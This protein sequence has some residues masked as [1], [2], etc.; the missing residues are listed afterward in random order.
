LRLGYK[1]LIPFFLLLSLAVVSQNLTFSPY[2]RYGIGEMNH[3]GFGQL[4]ALGGA[5]SAFKPDT[6]APVFINIV[7]PAAIS[8]IRVTTLEI[9]GI[10]NFS[11]Y[12]NG[13]SK[14]RTKTANFSY[15]ALG[16]NV[17]Q[18]A[19]LCFGIMP[20]SNVGYNIRSDVW[21]DN[22]ND[23]VTTKYSGD[24][25]INKVFLGIG[26]NPFKKQLTKFYRSG[27]RDSLMHHHQVKKYKRIKF[28]KE[29]L[30]DLSIGGRADYLFGNILQTSS[31]IYPGS[32][33]YYNTRRYRAVNYNDIT[34]SLGLQTSFVIDSVKKKKVNS[35]THFTLFGGD[36]VQRYE[37]KQ[38]IRIAFG[39]YVNIPNT[40]MVKNS[41]LAYN[42]SL[43]S[44]GDEIPKDTFVYAMD[45]QGSI[46]LPLEQGIG[47]SVKKGEVLN[48]TA[49]LTYTNW[50]Q[51][52]YLDKVNDLRNSYR[53]SFGINYVPNKF[54]LGKQNYYK[55]VNYR[56]GAFYNNGYLELKKSEI[57][58]YALTVGFGFPVGVI[59]RSTNNTFLVNTV[60]ISAHFGKMGT[61][62]NKL[63]EEKYIKLV[64]GFTFND[65]WFNKT[66]FD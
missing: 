10:G 11:D 21:S 65:K 46:R 55:R 28:A 30:S 63:I 39:Y 56:I 44:F 2:S 42:Y 14:V 45:Q 40:I 36:S 34:G 61:V 4:H 27:Y 17:K 38:K 53:V 6:V 51:F 8:N 35:K 7:N 16:F 60:N 5:A 1:I 25:G 52:R 64:V 23:Y 29:I 41:Y 49:D 48:V 57:V 62:N 12:N 31:V 26:V 50:Q 54:A 13:T 33:N 47:M 22:V 3:N 19:G 37:L 32:L 58:N 9:G 24:G 15:G 59:T 66:K 43:N 20:Y 18:K